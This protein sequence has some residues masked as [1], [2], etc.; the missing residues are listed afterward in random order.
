MSIASRTVGARALTG[1]VFGMTLW[2]APVVAAAQDKEPLTIGV[3]ASMSAAGADVGGAGSVAAA[4]M[5]IEDFGG[6]VDGREVRLLSG[7]H[8][9]KADIGSAIAR[10]WFEQNQVDVITDL[11]NSA[12]A[13][14]VLG[15]ARQQNKIVITTGA[16]TTVFSGEACAPTG[17]QWAFD[18]YGLAHG[19]ASE[20][21]KQGGN[22][23]FF[24]SADFAFGKALESAAA[25][26]VTAGGGQ[27]VGAVRHPPFTT[28]DFASFLLQA[29]ASPAQ[30][31][32]FSSGPPDYVLGAKQAH[33]F[34]LTDSGKRL[35]LLYATIADIHGMGLP[36][37]QGLYLT[38]AF[39]WDLDD[40]TRAW[41]KRFFE[42]TGRMPSMQQA[43]VYS[44][45]THYFKAV[46][47]AGSKDGPTVAAKM[48]ELPVE[49]FFARKGFIRADGRM[50]HDLY[51]VQV[52]SPKE[53][54]YPWDYYK[55]IETI[56]GPQSVIPADKSQ[57][58]LLAKK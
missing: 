24:I 27:V 12:V 57:C 22:T 45:L 13:L 42:K 50:V 21:L 29:A 33:E 35:A 28:S 8:Q 55:V 23:W 9:E 41:S 38:E 56:P 39:Y 36:S 10:N 6:K 44:A 46:A 53:S 34:G 43:G 14:A 7:D 19:T 5:A 15:I 30:V 32:A 31:I 18:T 20:L 51:L 52:K 2:L 25:D 26:V 40:K 54:K 17:F 37:A 49:D 1:A 16:G 4:K 3:L 58:P 48:K 47:A 11:P